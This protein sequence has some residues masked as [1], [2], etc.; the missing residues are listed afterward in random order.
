MRPVGAG[1]AAGAGGC[2]DCAWPRP[3]AKLRARPRRQFLLRSHL[4]LLNCKR[5]FHAG[6]RARACCPGCGRRGESRH[7]DVV[8]PGKVRPIQIEVQEPEVQGDTAA[9]AQ[10]ASGR[11]GTATATQPANSPPTPRPSRGR[12]TSAWRTC[13][14]PVS[15]HTRPCD[16]YSGHASDTRNTI[17]KNAGIHRVDADDEP[18]HPAHHPDS[19]PAQSIVI[20]TRKLK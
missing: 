4:K 17:R 10:A 11:R 14:T 12:R 13:K 7:G 6:Q 5:E 19:S 2:A 8:P 16:A 9:S 20:A 18:E 1:P 3:P 15:N